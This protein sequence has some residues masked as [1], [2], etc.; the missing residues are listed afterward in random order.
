[1]LCDLGTRHECPMS[2]GGVRLDLTGL[3][4]SSSRLRFSRN[5]PTRFPERALERVAPIARLPGRTTELAGSLDHGC[6]VAL[7]DVESLRWSRREHAASRTVSRSAF[8]LRS[9]N[10]SELPCDSVAA[11]VHV[12]A[13]TATATTLAAAASC[14]SAG[15][16][17]ATQR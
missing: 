10:V 1:M 5:F 16:A 3:V 8:T 2:F 14:I 9:S 17:S 4:S 7:V 6:R 12:A 13:A 11:S 15:T